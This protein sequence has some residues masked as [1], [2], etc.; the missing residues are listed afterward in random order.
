MNHELRI[1]TGSHPWIHALPSAKSDED[2]SQTEIKSF[3]IIGENPDYQM[4]LEM[5]FAADR[6]SV[7]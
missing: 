1:I 6:I 4:L 2:D 7:W 3:E 5:I